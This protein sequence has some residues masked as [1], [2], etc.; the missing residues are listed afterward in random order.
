MFVSFQASLERQFEFIQKQWLADGN[1]FGLGADRDP[2]VGSGNREG[3]GDLMVIQG[4]PPLYLNLPAFVS[5]RGG[6]YFLL[7]GRAGLRALATGQW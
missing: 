3:S 2:I 1:V 4:S 6:D 7:P 5:T